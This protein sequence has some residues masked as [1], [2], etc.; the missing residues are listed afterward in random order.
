MDLCSVV[1]H[2]RTER[3]SDV[4]SALETLEGVEIHAAEPDGRLVVTVESEEAASFGDTVL[5]LQNVDGVLNA[6]LVYHFHEEEFEN[7]L[8][9]IS[10]EETSHEAEPA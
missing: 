4:R 5:T 10:E 2:A 6:N 1:V 3:L 9:E 8:I 7:D